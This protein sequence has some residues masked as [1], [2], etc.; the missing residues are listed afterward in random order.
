[1]ERKIVCTHCDST[2]V[3]DVPG[4]D[5]VFQCR[6]CGEFFD[7]ESF[8]LQFIKTTRENRQARILEQY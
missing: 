4:V 3:D 8:E 6:E 1:M 7:D 2:D 5:G